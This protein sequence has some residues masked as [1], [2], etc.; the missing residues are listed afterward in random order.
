MWYFHMWKSGDLFEKIGLYQIGNGFATQSSWLWVCHSRGKDRKRGLWL[1]LVES[2]HSLEWSWK[3]A[4]DMWTYSNVLRSQWTFQGL[5]CGPL[6]IWRAAIIL[7]W[8]LLPSAF[9]QAVALFS[10][11]KAE[12]G[13]RPLRCSW[14]E[15]MSSYFMN[16]FVLKVEQ[17]WCCSHCCS[18]LL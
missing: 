3:L 8:L 4:P 6:C 18:V 2:C 10:I 5:Q 13:G 11:I 14:L 15:G 1:M 12:E 9:C 16:N 17:A 7:F